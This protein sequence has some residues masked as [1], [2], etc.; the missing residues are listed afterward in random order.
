MAA[1]KKEMETVEVE[2]K[3]RTYEV[4]K[5]AIMSVKS[6]RAMANASRDLAAAFDAMDAMCCGRLDEYA[7][8]VPEEDGTV[9][10]Y[11]A[12]TGAMVAF[13]NAAAEQAAGAKN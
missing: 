8:T 11:G 7:D 1:S 10:P 4:C 6:Q 5:P 3:G 12:S 13:L 9:L 2:Y